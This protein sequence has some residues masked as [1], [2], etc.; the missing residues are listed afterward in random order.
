MDQ[1][2]YIHSNELREKWKDYPIEFQMANIGS[3][4]SRALKWITKGNA[5]RADKA[6]DRALELFDFT[7]ESN[8][9]NPFRLMEILKAREEF[10]DYFFG[11]NSWHTDADKMQKYY[12]GFAM[13][14]QL[15]PNNTK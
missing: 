5:L 8:A 12:D 10:C 14:M 4:V 11:N 6:I 3:E 1:V 7:I 2:K 15:R 13:M 9:G